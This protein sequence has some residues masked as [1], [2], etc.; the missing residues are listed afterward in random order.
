MGKA[1]FSTE[2]GEKIKKIQPK[3]K[4]NQKKSRGGEKW[5]EKY[6]LIFSISPTVE[7][8]NKKWEDFFDPIQHINSL[9]NQ[10]DRS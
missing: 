8:W 10:M 5:Y 4:I 2:Y 6:S 3:K 1:Y 7:E 9:Y